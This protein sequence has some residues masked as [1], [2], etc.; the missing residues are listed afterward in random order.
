MPAPSVPLR[1]EISPGGGLLADRGC[2]AA[3]LERQQRTCRAVELDEPR[4]RQ[5][6][7]AWRVGVVP[8]FVRGGVAVTCHGVVV[9]CLAVELDV[10]AVIQVL[11][12]DRRAPGEPAILAQPQR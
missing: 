2:I 8:N 10:I 7:T 11:D 1:V 3:W 12:H 5:T 4:S 9:L 6:P